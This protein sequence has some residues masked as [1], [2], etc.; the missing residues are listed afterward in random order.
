MTSGTATATASE[1]H[2]HGELVNP[3]RIGGLT[4]VFRRRFLLKLLVQKEL[5]VRYQGSVVGLAWSYVKPAV[6]FAMYYW[7]IGLLL[8]P[9]SLEDRA[10]HIFAGM[11]MVSF[12]SDALSAGSKSV[13]RNKA[14]V[15]KINLPR[16]MFPVASI[17]V[18]VYHMV[19]MY[20]IIV[21]GCALSGWTFDPMAL[22]AAVMAFAIVFIWGLASALVLSACNVY[23][24]DVAN[25]VDVIT[26]IITWTVPMIYPF[27]LVME[28]LKDSH[29]WLYELYLSS[30]LCI[31]VLLNDRAF[32]LPAT[33]HPVANEKL[34]L[35][36]DLWLRGVGMIVVGLVFL[37]FAQMLF[38]RL[39]GRFAEKL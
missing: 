22:V 18:S 7:V 9:R 28:R 2:P 4:D 17:M 20:V 1:P 14:L 36:A 24:R 27:V 32:W 35:P 39:E 3:G 23:Y 37:W 25:V 10:L 26:T 6:R 8:G 11:I 38:S 33:D 21:L 19:A 16:E 12:F 5:K 30:P 29:Q 13:V 15:R 31:A 34:Q